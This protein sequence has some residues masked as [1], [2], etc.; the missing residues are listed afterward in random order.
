MT[1]KNGARAPTGSACPNF[2]KLEPPHIDAQSWRLLVELAGDLAARQAAA[3]HPNHRA[4]LQHLTAQIN[5]L[6]QRFEPPKGAA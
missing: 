1:I 2:A 3:E 4:D 6:L 5:S